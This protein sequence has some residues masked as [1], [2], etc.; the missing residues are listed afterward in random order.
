[1]AGDSEVKESMFGENNAIS[2]INQT[3]WENAAVHGSTDIFHSAPHSAS[4]HIGELTRS[5]VARR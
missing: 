5:S 2:K 4:W 1:M 3:G